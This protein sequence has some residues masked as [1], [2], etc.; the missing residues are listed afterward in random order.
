MLRIDADTHVQLTEETWEYMTES[1]RE[2][3]PILVEPIPGRNFVPGDKRPH[4]AWIIDGRVTL[5]QYR[6]DVRSGTT[7]ATRELRDVQARM[8]HMD[9]LG[10]DVQ[11]LYPN[12][13]LGQVTENPDVEVALCRSY[14]RWLAEKTAEANGR[15]R[16]VIVPPLHN[17][18]RALEELRFG[19]E[20]GA[21]GVFKRAIDCG[22]KPVSNPYFFPLYGEAMRLDLPICIHTGGSSASSRSMAASPDERGTSGLFI[23]QTLGCFGALATRRIPDQ[24]PAVRFGVI[25]AMASW[26]PYI[27]A[28]M[29][30][31]VTYNTHRDKPR[32]VNFKEDFLRQNRFYVTLHVS[33]D[34]P[35]LL[36]FG[37]EDSLMIG[38]DYAHEDA[39]SVQAALDMVEQLGE[40]GEITMEVARKILDDNP[41]AFYGL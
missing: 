15:L 1:E 22:G 13:F 9:E 40:T 38:T 41:R 19:K 4:Q 35:Y 16:W 7:A 21:C 2:F 30:A 28:K 17:M 25:E 27:I 18:E 20:H 5:N 3:K 37:A 34:V 39:A 33:D 26:I 31:Q 8:R 12:V 23:D 11:V 24:F 6:D 14:N 10:A 32:E 29:T 36:K